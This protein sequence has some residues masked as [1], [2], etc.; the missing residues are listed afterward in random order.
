[1]AGLLAVT[2]AIGIHGTLMISDLDK[3]PGLRTN[4][5]K[6]WRPEGQVTWHHKEAISPIQ[7]VGNST[8]KGASFSNKLPAYG[9][10]GGE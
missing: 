6:I 5:R 7:N 3:P 10:A 1:M 4:L 8:D 9:R 2:D